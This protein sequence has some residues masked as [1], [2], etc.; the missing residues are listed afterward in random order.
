MPLFNWG[1][2]KG[3]GSASS[4]VST[5]ES[6][7]KRGR[8]ENGRL[9]AAYGKN[10][11]ASPFCL[12]GSRLIGLE[13]GLPVD[14]YEWDRIDMNHHKY[15]L[16]QN[17]KLFLAPLPP[18]PQKILDVGTGTGMSRPLWIQVSAHSWFSR[19]LCH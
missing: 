13:Y 4:F 2:S 11:E 12:Y 19:H 7:I 1:R 6:E 18:N 5:I 15:T 14:E 3:L 16:A 17:D 8:E 9:Y 10:G